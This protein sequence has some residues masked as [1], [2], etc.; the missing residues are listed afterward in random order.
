MCDS[1]R[2]RHPLASNLFGNSIILDRRFFLKLLL[3]LHEILMAPGHESIAPNRIWVDCLSG[4]I[5]TSKLITRITYTRRPPGTPCRVV[6]FDI[7]VFGYTVVWL[8]AKWSFRKD[9]FLVLLLCLFIGVGADLLEASPLRGNRERRRDLFQSGV[10][11]YLF[12]FLF[13][14]NPSLVL[15][16]RIY[17]RCP[18]SCGVWAC[19]AFDR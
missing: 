4:K 19:S 1:I 8:V 15:I 13:D 17:K 5:M 18:K 12:Q 14:L 2:R 6:G 10:P 3:E 7:I 9:S 16:D 11:F